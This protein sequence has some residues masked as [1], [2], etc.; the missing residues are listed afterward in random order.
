LALPSACHHAA[1]P[2]GGAT[3][4]LWATPIEFFR[5]KKSAVKYKSA[6]NFRKQAS[7]IIFMSVGSFL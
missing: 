5:I 1:R 3:Q 6:L 2:D 7:K 4:L